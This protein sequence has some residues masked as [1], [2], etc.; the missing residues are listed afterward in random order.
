MDSP[1][2]VANEAGVD[3]VG[4]HQLLVRAALDLA[5]PVKDNDEIGVADSRQTVCHD[6]AGRPAP[7]Q[8]VVDEPLG[9]RVEGT[10]GLVEDEDA[11][12][13]HQGAR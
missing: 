3:S 11:R 2:L 4:R 8:I 12:L 7:P 13:P 6:D 9:L 10:R 1:L 5:S